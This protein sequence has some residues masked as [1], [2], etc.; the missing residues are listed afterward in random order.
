MSKAAAD[1][2]I[3][4]EQASSIFNR[5]ATLEVRNAT[6]RKLLFTDAAHGSGEFFGGAPGPVIEPRTSQVFG[7][8]SSGLFTGTDGA[9][10]WNVEGTDLFYQITWSVPFAGNNGTNSFIEGPGS[11]HLVLFHSGGGGNTNVPMKYMVGEKAALGDKDKDWRLCE[12]CKCLF[13]ATNI[14]GSDCAAG[15]RHQ[16]NPMSFNFLLPHSTPGISHQGNWRFCVRC[17]GIFF[18]GI[19]GK[20]GVCPAPVPPVHEAEGSF[21]LQHTFNVDVPADPKHQNFWR[22]C[23]NCFGMFS[24]ASAARGCQANADGAHERFP[25]NGVLPP[26]HPLSFLIDKRPFN[27][28]LEVRSDPVPKNREAG[29]VPCRKCCMLFFAPEAADSKCPLGDVHEVDTSSQ[30]FQVSPEEPGPE[31]GVFQKNWAKCRKCKSMFF[32]GFERGRCSVP[33]PPGLRLGHK[34]GG[35]EFNLPHD[36]PGPGQNE[37]R[38][39]SKCFCLLLEPLSA[40]APCAA[41]GQHVPQGFDFRL[42]HL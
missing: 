27:Y 28:R 18:D 12:K 17:T 38:F 3:A 13:R 10:Q 4:V 6:G 39:C 25:D 8:G 15:G 9:A 42:D 7:T 33:N 29:W 40:G 34:A 41:G 24:E 37:W 32:N 1:A 35:V 30:T 23:I 22:F 21:F 31:E 14:E 5:S 19:A 36:F 2:I 26:G 20:K 11:Q 16:H